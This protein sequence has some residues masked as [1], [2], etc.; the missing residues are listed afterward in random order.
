MMAQDIDMFDML[1]ILNLLIDIIIYLLMRWTYD[2][3]ILKFQNKNVNIRF[4][5][6]KYVINLILIDSIKFVEQILILNSLI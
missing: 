6:E 2:E 3:V 5:R 1:H 4:Y